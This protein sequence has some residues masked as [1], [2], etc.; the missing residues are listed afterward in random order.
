MPIIWPEAFSG[1]FLKKLRRSVRYVFLLVI[2]RFIE[3]LP[4]TAFSRL[5]RLL[6]KAIPVFFS[7][8]ME[9]A[10]E[11]L[12]EEFARDREKII[13]G[14]IDNQVLTLLEVF[15]YEKLLAADSNFIH[16]TGVEHLE[17][18]RRAGRGILILSA[19]FGSWE[20]VAYTLVKMGYP[21][22]IIVRPQAINQMTELINGFRERRGMR[23]LMENNLNAAMKIL[24]DGGMIG[25]VSDLNAR[26]RGYRVPFF[27]R[28]A[29]FYH[30]PIL[31]SERTRADLIPVSIFRQP[32]GRHEIIIEPPL[33]W[34][35][36]DSMTNKVRTY[37][38][39]YESM[40]RRCPG[41][42]VWFHER[43]VHADLG[44]TG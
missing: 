36:H 10:R 44:R 25:I 4:V 21:L 39:R 38:A 26:E 17:A 32:S 37:V 40:I 13:S 19:H 2:I 3:N 7:R 28:E 18:A 43:Y 30:A 5:K 24:R 34:D 1:D 12:P 42:W 35:K 6:R 31:L 23:I 15:F 29:S 16:V 41:Q 14:V 9:R 8:Q 20:L 11:L 33:S 22:Q 27:G